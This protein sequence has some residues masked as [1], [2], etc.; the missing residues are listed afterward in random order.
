L[1]ASSALY[2]ADENGPGY[3]LRSATTD[4]LRAYLDGTQPAETAWLSPERQHEEAWFL[5]LRM[6]A[7]VEIAALVREFGREMVG[8]ALE[9]CERLAADGLLGFDGKTARLTARGRLLSNEVFQ[10]FLTAAGEEAEG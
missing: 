10:E 8:P 7:G 9:T 6:N 1:D 5:G 3:L 4:D 2:A